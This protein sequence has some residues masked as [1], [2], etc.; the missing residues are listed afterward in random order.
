[1]IPLDLARFIPL[2]LIIG[3]AAYSDWKTKEVT[4]KLWLYAI[5]G[6]SLTIIETMFFLN[7]SFLILELL[8]IGFT[9][10]IGYLFFALKQW[11]GADAKALMTIGLSAPLFPTWGI[12]YNSPIPLNMFPFITLSIASTL[13]IIYTILTKSNIPLKQRK[14]KF[15]PFMLA[16]IIIAVIL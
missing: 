8:S 2:C 15:M 3:Y 16:G 9:I 1:M 7:S 10:I 6:L 4:N 14:I 13:T 12:L 11:G 5:P